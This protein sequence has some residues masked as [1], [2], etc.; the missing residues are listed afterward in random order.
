M[1]K[2]WVPVGKTQAALGTTLFPS[3]NAVEGGQ[4]LAAFTQQVIQGKEDSRAILQK[5]QQGIEAVS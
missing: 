4:A 3:L 2:E 1:A 5:L